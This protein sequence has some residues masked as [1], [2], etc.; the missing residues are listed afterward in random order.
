MFLKGELVPPKEAQ[1]SPRPDQ[2]RVETQKQSSKRKRK[3]KEKC[4]YF[5]FIQCL[6]YFYYL[7]PV[8]PEYF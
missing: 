2:Q 4:S 8:F 3:K 5:F 6:R 1:V 7:I